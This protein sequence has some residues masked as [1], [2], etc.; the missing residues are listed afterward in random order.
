MKG[1]VEDFVDGKYVFGGE[2]FDFDKM[3]QFKDD[4]RIR[5]ISGF[6]VVFVKGIIL[7]RKQEK[8]SEFKNKQ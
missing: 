1:E 5:C 4:E 2:D 3:C 6:G 7:D 8:Y